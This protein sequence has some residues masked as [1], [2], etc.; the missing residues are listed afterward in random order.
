MKRLTVVFMMVAAFGLMATTAAQAVT[1]QKA[2][3]TIRMGLG[4]E[5]NPK[6]AIAFD[7]FE[8]TPVKG[9]ITYTNFGLADAGSGVWAPGSAF[10]VT[11]GVD[12]S[13]DIVSTYDFTIAT[14]TPL[15]PTSLS[16]TGNGVQQVYG[17]HGPVTG[18]VSGST[19]T[20]TL[21]EQN[22]ADPQSYT[23]NAT[24]QIDANG[25]VTLGTW[26]DNY[27]GVRTGTFNIADVGDEVFSFTT[28]PTCV[29]VDD[30]L[31]TPKVTRFGYTIPAGAPIVDGFD[32]AGQPVAVKVTDNGSSGALNDT[33]RHNFATALNRCDPKDATYTQYP[34]TAGNLTVFN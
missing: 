34:I 4:T 33:Y 27:G 11:F 9:N 18:T 30:G 16:F 21:I 26:N 7:V 31:G 17:W 20:F 19:L 12:P 3:G 2:T 6:Q 24:G 8:T 14:T 13:T 15:S 23:L 1:A 32:L 28:T 10:A 22:D 25:A 5:T 29:Q